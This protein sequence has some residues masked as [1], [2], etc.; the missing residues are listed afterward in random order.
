M[1]LH[2]PG[3]MAGSKRSKMPSLP[4][5]VV[6]LAVCRGAW[7]SSVWPFQLDSLSFL[8][9]WT[10]KLKDFIGLRSGCWPTSL[11][12]HSI[13]RP[14]LTEAEGRW[15]CLWMWAGAPPT[16]K[17]QAVCS[18]VFGDGAHQGCCLLTQNVQ[19]STSE[20]LGGQPVLRLSQRN[21]SRYARNVSFSLSFSSLECRK[22]FC[23]IVI[24]VEWISDNHYIYY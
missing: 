3:S 9:W 14:A 21:I 11:L 10:V 13:L 5:L 8:M 22:P 20:E 23:Y 16:A 2:S 19:E 17:E 6:V 18:A 4:C 12:L 24:S 7:F 1:W 15:P